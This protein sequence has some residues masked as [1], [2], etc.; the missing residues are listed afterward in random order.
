MRNTSLEAVIEEK[1]LGVTIHQDLKFH[2]HVS[3]VVKKSIE[4]AWAG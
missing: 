3:K 2:L 1:N 4:N